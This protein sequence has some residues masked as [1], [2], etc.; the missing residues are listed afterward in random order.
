LTCI[1]YRRRMSA[2]RKE[3][4]PGS[5]WLHEALGS[6][7]IYEVVADHGDHI[8]VRVRQAPGLAEGTRIR[9]TRAAVEAM[10]QLPGDESAPRRD[11]A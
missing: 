8:D 9:L 10:R 11:D 2:R 7:A 4:E 1:V 3:I 5:R 6:E